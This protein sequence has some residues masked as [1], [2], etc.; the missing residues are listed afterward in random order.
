MFKCPGASIPI[1][2]LLGPMRITVILTSLPTRIRSPGFLDKTSMASLLFCAVLVC[3]AQCAYWK[4]DRISPSGAIQKARWCGHCDDVIAKS[5]A[6]QSEKIELIT[7]SLATS[8]H[9][10]S[11]AILQT[12]GAR[13]DRRGNSIGLANNDCNLFGFPLF[14]AV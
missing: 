2:T 4:Y 13:P 12:E 6:R 7:N 10:L 5:T 9:A 3:D 8:D 11:T 14:S 1:R